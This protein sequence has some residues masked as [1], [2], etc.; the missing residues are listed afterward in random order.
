MAR[1]VSDRADRV[2][3]FEVMDLVG[4]A[5]ERERR[6]GPPGP[7]CHL[8]VGQPSAPAPRRVLE[9]ARAALDLPLTYTESLGLPELRSAIAGWYH[10]RH[11]LELDPERVAVTAG[12]S[13]G[14]VL[15]FLA[16]FDP[17]ERVGVCVPGYPCYRHMLEV[18]GCEAVPVPL[19]HSS[20]YR[21]TPELLDGCGPLDGLVV[22]SP[23]NPTGTTLTPA[24]LDRLLAWCAAHDVRL[25]ADEIYHGIDAGQAA[26]TAAADP[27]AVVVQS[28]SK[29]FRMT[30]WRLG[31]LVLP[32]ELCRPVE[33]L[34]Q[35]LYLAP[36]TLAQRAA[37]AA[38]N[39]TDELDVE[40][41]RYAINRE[42]LVGGLHR[43]GVRGIAPADGA[44]YVWADVAHLGD[45]RELCR[46]WLE[47]LAVA[48]TPGVDF[49]PER[50]RRFVRFSVAGPTDEVRAATE[51]LTGWIAA[52]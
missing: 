28:F 42:L 32:D 6:A 39:A 43:V 19:E 11:G 37:V 38:F 51:R 14:C 17:G 29:Y 44:F 49:D 22:A 16:S 20:G 52:R 4:L 1:R 33:R 13:A 8:E 15:A 10:Q 24:E 2:P 12:A 50:G 9:A 21:P 48:A 45:S 5:A 23:S 18:L 41:R 3:A 25:V 7:V 46:R 26:P 34:A 47:E 36:P 40:V 27:D 31:W 35:N 30:G